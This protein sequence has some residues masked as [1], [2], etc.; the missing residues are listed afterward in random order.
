MRQRLLAALRLELLD[1]LLR[2]M[3]WL[4]FGLALLIA[5]ALFYL[6]EGFTARILILHAAMAAFLLMAFRAWREKR[7]GCA[8]ALSVTPLR[9]HE[10]LAAKVLLLTGLV[11]MENLGLGQVSGRLRWL[12]IWLPGTCVVAA[13]SA[14]LGF[15]AVGGSL[16]L[17]R[18]F[19]N[20]RG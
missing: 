8:A 5:A 7:D 13:V 10:Y 6:P 4:A 17:R 3:H 1:F 14:A 2:G 9:P 19:A 20:W 15:L 11:A 12:W 16:S 18:A